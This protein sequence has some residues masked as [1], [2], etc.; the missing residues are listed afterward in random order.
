MELRI[1]NM[2]DERQNHAITAPAN[3]TAKAT[4]PIGSAAGIEAA[5]DMLLD[6]ELELPPEEPLPCAAPGLLSPAVELLYGNVLL[7]VVSR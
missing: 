3:T 2:H 7:V 4:S 5:R 1:Q 6:E